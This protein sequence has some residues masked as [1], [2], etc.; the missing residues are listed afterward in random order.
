[1]PEK[2]NIKIVDFQRELTILEYIFGLNLYIDELFFKQRVSILDLSPP[3]RPSPFTAA[4]QVNFALALCLLSLKR[5]KGS[6]I[7]IA[8]CCGFFGGI[9]GIL[10]LM[11]YFLNAKELYAVGHM[12]AIAAHTAIGFILISI[13]IL[14]LEPQ[15]ALMRTFTSQTRT[16]EILRRFVPLALWVPVLIGWFRLRGQQIGLYS[17]E[18]GLA[19]MVTFCIVSWE[20]AIFLIARKFQEVE[21][22]LS[23][24]EQ[25]LQSQ[26]D[27]LNLTHDAI[28]VRD[29]D[30]KITFW[31]NGAEKLY[32]YL[33]VEA[34]GKTVHELLQTNFPIER[35]NIE[36]NILQFGKWE[37]EL[38]HHTKTGQT[39][40]VASRWSI[41]RMRQAIQSL[42]SRLIMI[43]V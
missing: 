6:A 13:G 26:A 37:G 34:M 3:G 30:G 17:F 9:I 40:V 19:I 12:T 32:G 42:F 35:E 36:S 31:N 43:L 38:T 15:L 23:E 14:F 28:I 11:G 21:L 25:Q 24:R 22:V 2:S 16:G 18:S 27:L 41:K 5:E 4:M 20:L 29:L 39:I 10:A 1:M 33:R 8:Q 7:T